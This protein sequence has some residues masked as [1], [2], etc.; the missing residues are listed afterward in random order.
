MKM[1]PKRAFFLL[2]QRLNSYLFWQLTPIFLPRLLRWT[3]VT[4]FVL[5]PPTASKQRKKTRRKRRKERF[6]GWRRCPW[7]PR[8]GKR[9]LMKSLI[10]LVMHG[11]SHRIKSRAWSPIMLLFLELP[12]RRRFSPI[13]FVSFLPFSHLLS[14]S[15]GSTQNLERQEMEKVP[16]AKTWFQLSSS[17]QTRSNP[18]RVP[19]VLLLQVLLFM[20]DFGRG[21]RRFLI[22][23]WSGVFLA[24]NEKSK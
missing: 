2:N 5:H 22:G 24:K 16:S 15:L 18:L 8:Q 13:F 12:R 4:S 11:G 10:S 9:S 17:G 14:R 19:L 6:F 3:W 20:E 23:R 1:V 7:W 21:I